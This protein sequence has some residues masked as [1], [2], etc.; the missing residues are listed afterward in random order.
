MEK[1]YQ[2]CAFAAFS[3]V[4]LMVTEDMSQKPRLFISLGLLVTIIVMSV[5]AGIRSRRNIE[6]ATKDS[7]KWYTRSAYLLDLA[8]LDFAAFVKLAGLKY[9]RL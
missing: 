1:F 9:T 2:T 8:V 6:F 3:I 4:V 5:V 7:I